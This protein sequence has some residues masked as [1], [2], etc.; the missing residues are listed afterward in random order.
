MNVYMVMVTKTGWGLF[1][2]GSSRPMIQDSCREVVLQE[3]K[4]LFTGSGVCI[5]LD[6]ENG[7]FQELR[8]P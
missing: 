1:K 4:L 3:A 8:L 6:N 2:K 7:T 5:R